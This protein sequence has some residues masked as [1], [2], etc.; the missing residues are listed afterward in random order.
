[1]SNNVEAICPAGNGVCPAECPNNRVARVL[2]EEFGDKLDPAVLRA[3]LL[4]ADVNSTDIRVV[5]VSRLL[6][7]CVNE[8]PERSLVE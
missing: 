6:A 2:T 7:S 1:M 3:K 4:F 5:M 8:K